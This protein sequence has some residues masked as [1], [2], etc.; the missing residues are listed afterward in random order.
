M[1]IALEG[2]RGQRYAPAALYPRKRAG[3]QKMLVLMFKCPHYG[4]N[5]TKYAEQRNLH[6]ETLM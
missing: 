6:S 3:T 5:M 1:T 4:L 2:M